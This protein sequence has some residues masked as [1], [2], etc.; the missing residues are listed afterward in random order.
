[1]ISERLELA[2]FPENSLVKIPEPSVVFRYQKGNSV[3]IKRI[4]YSDL[5]DSVEKLNKER[6]QLQRRLSELQRKERTGSGKRYSSA[7]RKGI[8]GQIKSSLAQT[9]R[10]RK[11]LQV[12]GK[13]LLASPG[14]DPLIVQIE[15]NGEGRLVSGTPLEEG[16]AAWRVFVFREAKGVLNSQD[17]EL[18]K[19][20]FGIRWQLAHGSDLESELYK[21]LPR[22]PERPDIDN[23][24]SK[25]PEFV[26]KPLLPG[27][28]ILWRQ[29]R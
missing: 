19:E 28:E 27:L 3:E 29:N 18:I 4:T 5:M 26:K 13:W 20:L 25:M 1:M 21:V 16:E 6:S 14:E 7:E 8:F 17:A 22:I 15:T 24:V 10:N 11:T 2:N 23:L 9:E 12:Q